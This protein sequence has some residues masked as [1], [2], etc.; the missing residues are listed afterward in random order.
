MVVVILSRGLS[1]LVVDN[2]L[3]ATALDSVSVS[4]SECGGAA[5]SDSWLLYYAL[6]IAFAHPNI[7]GRQFKSTQQYKH[8]NDLFFV[9]IIKFRI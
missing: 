5:E 4:R 8:P 9:I 3:R 2:R 6:R 1:M 7:G